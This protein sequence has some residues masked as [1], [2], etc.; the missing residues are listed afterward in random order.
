MMRTNSKRPKANCAWPS[1]DDCV[2]EMVMTYHLLMTVAQ[3]QAQPR[4]EA[5]LCTGP[6]GLWD[7]V[8]TSDRHL[9]AMRL[10]CTTWH[11]NVPLQYASS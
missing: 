4:P 10:K 11:G 5:T 2:M 9:D 1:S 3:S 6:S 8:P 7:L